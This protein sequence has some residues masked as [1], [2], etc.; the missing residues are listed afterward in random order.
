MDSLR[1]SLQFSK[2]AF[3]ACYRAQEAHDLWTVAQPFSK[4]QPQTTKVLVRADADA[5]SVNDDS[6]DAQRRLHF[7][8]QSGS[9]HT[10]SKHPCDEPLLHP[11]TKQK[12]SKCADILA[13]V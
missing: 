5:A 11:A 7:G 12:R 10:R 8:K 3:S 13:C 4:Q 1:Q 6:A 9:R 2:S